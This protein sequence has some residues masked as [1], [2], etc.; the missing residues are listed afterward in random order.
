M[1]PDFLHSLALAAGVV[2]LLITTVVDKVRKIVLLAIT[3]LVIVRVGVGA[4]T[5]TTGAVDRPDKTTI[6]VG[7]IVTVTSEV[8]VTVRVEAAAVTVS[9][10]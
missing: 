7:V 3:P 4:V 9:F 1:P 6:G 5:V 8:D 10:T 2:V